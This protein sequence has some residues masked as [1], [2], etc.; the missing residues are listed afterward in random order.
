MTQIGGF[1][2]PT[3]RPDVLGV[4]SLDHFSLTVPDMEV[5][6]GFYGGFGLEVRAQGGALQL[7][8]VGSDHR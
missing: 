7:H 4:H 1:I 5:A 8:T 3:R 6:K 2:P